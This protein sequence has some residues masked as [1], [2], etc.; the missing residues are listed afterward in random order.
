MDV[1]GL[2]GFHPAEA[3]AG[4]RSGPEAA[5]GAPL[6]PSSPHANAGTSHRFGAFGA[7]GDARQAAETLRKIARPTERQPLWAG[8]ALPGPQEDRLKPHEGRNRRSFA[9]YI[10]PIA[11]LSAIKTQEG[12][13]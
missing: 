3:G 10:K 4:V 12:E 9:M 13:I 7:T 8:E 6:R 2:G 1:A 5:V 11:K